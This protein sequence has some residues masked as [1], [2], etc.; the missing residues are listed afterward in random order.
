MQK[1]HKKHDNVHYINNNYVLKPIYNDENECINDSLSV[2]KCLFMNA[3]HVMYGAMDGWMDICFLKS[4]SYR[5][6]FY[7]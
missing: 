3:P 5:F 2:F 4:V 1:Y 7:A 6:K